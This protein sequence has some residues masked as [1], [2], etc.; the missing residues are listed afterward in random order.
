MWFHLKK[1]KKSQ[2]CWLMPVILALGRPR[3]RIVSLRPARAIKQDPVLNKIIKL[4]VH[5]CAFA[6]GVCVTFDMPLLFSLPS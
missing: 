2:L 1:R 6:F 3:G 4:G 5:V